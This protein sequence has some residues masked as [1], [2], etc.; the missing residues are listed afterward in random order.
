MTVYSKV[1]LSTFDPI[2]SKFDFTCGTERLTSIDRYSYLGIMLTV[3][4]DFDAT[5]KLIEHSRAL[6]LLTVKY[7]SMGGMLYDAFT[8]LMTLLSGQN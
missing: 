1:I 6:G 7:K 5:A 2:R 8:K 3:F 4:L